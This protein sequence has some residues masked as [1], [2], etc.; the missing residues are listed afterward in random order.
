MA[1][2]QVRATLPCNSRETSGAVAAG[3]ALGVVGS[4]SMTCL[5]RSTL[6]QQRSLQMQFKMVQKCPCESD[7]GVIWAEAMPCL[8]KAGQLCVRL[9][10]KIWLKFSE[11]TKPSLVDIENVLHHHW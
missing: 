8:G 7:Q 6:F 5:K 11:T 4:G 3:Q 9:M 10:I 1:M 2:G